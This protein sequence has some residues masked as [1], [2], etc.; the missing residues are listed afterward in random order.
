MVRIASASLLFAA[1]ALAAP[2][3][4]AAT[5]GAYPQKPI[6]F[7]IPFPPGGGTDILARALSDKLEKALGAPVIIDNR[8]GAGG[9]VGCAMAARAEP[10]GYTLLYT[11]A[12]Y[13]FAPGLYKDLAY[14]AV[15]DFRPITMFATGPLILSV[16]PS[17]PVRNV[18]GLLALARQRPGEILYAS[19]GVGSNIHL[20]TELFKYMAKIDLKQVPYKGGGPASIALISGEVHV[21]F[22][23]MT[24]SMPFMKTGKMRAL[25]VTTK[26]RSPILPQLPTIHES[27]VPGYDKGA[28]YGL[29]APAAVPGPIIAHVYQSVAKVLKDPD[30]AKRLASEGAVAVG[31]PPEEFGKFVRAEID[32]WSK[33]IREMK[34]APQ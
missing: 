27:G 17:M 30:T 28:W 23:S 3:A 13:T 34:L 16:H 12:S 7:L 6:R 22:L 33:L 9:T 25:A 19:A 32:E 31:N 11:S 14:D 1:L 2:A 26:E 29:F 5:A 24:G 21:V 10:D 15:K 8:G 4:A 18:K 20:S